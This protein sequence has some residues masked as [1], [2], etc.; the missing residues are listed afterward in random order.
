M[1]RLESGVAVILDCIDDNAR[2]F[3]RRWGFRPLPGHNNRLF[4]RWNQ[5]E[6]MAPS[7]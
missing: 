2:A 6:A 1:P 4:F 5:L 3:C 7:R